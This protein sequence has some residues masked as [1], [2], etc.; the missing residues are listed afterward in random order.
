MDDVV[1]HCRAVLGHGEGEGAE[2]HER[3]QQDDR[4]HQVQVREI[5]D[6]SSHTRDRGDD[7]QAHDHEQGRDQADGAGFRRAFFADVHQ[8]SHTGDRIDAIDE[9]ADAEADGDRHAQ[10]RR[11]HAQNVHDVADEGVGQG[12]QDRRE[13]RAD[14]QRHAARIGVVREGQARHHIDRPGV[15]AVVQEGV[16]VRRGDGLFGVARDVSGNHDRVRAPEPQRL[17]RG[18]DHQAH[19]QTGAEHHGEPGKV[20]EFGL[21]AFLAEDAFSA[22]GNDRDCEAEKGEDAHSDDVEG[23]ETLQQR[24]V[25]AGENPVGAQWPDQRPDHQQRHGDFTDQRNWKAV[26]LVEAR[27]GFLNLKI[28]EWRFDRHSP[29]TSLGVFI[30]S[31][32]HSSLGRVPMTRFRQITVRF[33]RLSA[34]LP[35]PGL[36]IAI[37]TP[38]GSPIR[39]LLFGQVSNFSQNL[40]K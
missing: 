11:D 4:E 3:Q 22:R 26:A 29:S 1:H 5:L 18:V 39:A 30:D 27:W 32:T 35:Q 14:G 15:E 31:L 33:R 13:R 24:P 16:A 19:A 23:V 6:A 36:M 2:D 8:P 34:I 20:R 12:T 17:R 25:H 37:M 40:N 38:Y 7:R 9:L 28:C 10:D 21:L